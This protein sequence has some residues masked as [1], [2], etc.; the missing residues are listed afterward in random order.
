M[1]QNADALS[2]SIRAFLPPPVCRSLESVVECWNTEKPSLSLTIIPAFEL[3]DALAA[4][5]HDVVHMICESITCRVTGLSDKNRKQVINPSVSDSLLFRFLENY[6]NQLEGPLA[7]QVWHRFLQLAKDVISNIKDS[8]PQVFPVL[9]CVS[10]LADKITQ[11]TALEDRRI[12]KDLQET[13]GKLL[14]ATV[15]SVNRST[16]TNYWPRRNLKDSHGANGR[17]SPLPGVLSDVRLDEKPISR[18]ATPPPGVDRADQGP[19][20][21]QY[22][23]D[24]AL[25]RLRKFLVDN[26]RVL[27]VCTNIM[28]YI[29]S[30]ALKTKSRPLDFDP[31]ISIILR[32]MTRISVAIKTWRSVVSDIVND[33]R[34]FTCSVEAGMNSRSII[35]AWVDTDKSAFV[36]FLGKVTSAPSTNIF[37]NRETE[38]QL[39]SMNMRRMSYILLCG[40]KNQFLTSLPTIQ[41]KLVDTLKNTSAPVVQAEVYLCVRVLMCRL[42]QHNLDSFWPVILSE[43]YRLLEQTM[44]EIPSDGSEALSL[45]LSV[46]KF[47]DLLLVLQTEEFQM[48]Q[49]IFVTDTIDAVYRPDEIPPEAMLDQLSEIAGG[50]PPPQ[51]SAQNSLNAAFGVL[52][53][54]GSNPRMLRRPMLTHLRQ[55]D[56][57]RDLVSFFSIVSVATYES[58]YSS[59]GNID[60]DEVERGLLSDMFEPR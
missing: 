3:V 60:W 44:I 37:T 50:L 59:G 30:P 56:S 39:R 52:S 33:S 28:Y 35:Q 14:D 34:F 22:I 8:R 21:V 43:M 54:P 13:Y 49:W 17:D 36:D 41:E 42:S 48:H 32:E 38:N 29:V 19:H 53:T 20:I 45:I 16:D 4:S 7:V 51:E 23:G 46:C 27:T 2:K 1:F 55:I 6:L 11:T 9:R 5:A 10:I 12:R 25:P 26:D 40:E 24:I 31:T 15:V 58:I 47:I 57:I 18:P